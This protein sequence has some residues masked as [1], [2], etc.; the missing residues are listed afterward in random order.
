MLH[1]F[2]VHDAPPHLPG[3]PEPPQVPTLLTQSP[4]LRMPPQPFAHEPHSTPS[5]VQVVGTHDVPAHLPPVLHTIP[6]GQ[7]PQ[8]V[9]VPPQPSGAEPQSMP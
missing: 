7:V 3:T 9:I 5:A 1:V 8:L 4:Q 2:G 6:E